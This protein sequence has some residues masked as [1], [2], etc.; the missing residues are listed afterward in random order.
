MLVSSM[1]IPCNNFFRTKEIHTETTLSRGS[2]APVES[3]PR[4]ILPFTLEE[5]EAPHEFSGCSSN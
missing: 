5:R 4:F 1:G 3:G 2:A